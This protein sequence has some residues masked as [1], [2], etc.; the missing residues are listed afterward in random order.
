MSI[1]QVSIKQ[2][3]TMKRHLLIIPFFF[4]STLLFAQ[5]EKTS[6]LYTA[7]L[8]KDSLLFNV[9]FNTCD[10]SQFEQLVSDNFEFYHDKGGMV[11]TKADFISSIKS[12][13]CDNDYQ[14]I[15]TLDATSIEIYPLYTN[16]ILY[17]AIQNGNHRFYALEENAPMYLT[18]EAKFTHVWLLENEE[19][20]LSRSLSFNHI[21]FDKPIDK[22][23]LFKDKKETE[24]WLKQKGI[25]ALGI[26]YI[27]NGRIEQV[28]VFG[29]LQKGTEAPTNTLW[30]V[31]S[32]TK[33]I[34]TL[35]TLKLASNGH[36]DLDEPVYHYWIDPD[37]K[38]D[39][40]HKTMTTRHI[41]SH[42]TGFPNWRWMDEEAQNK[43]RFQFDP[44][45]A[46]QYSGEGFEYLK[47]ALE[48]KFNTS[49]EELADSLIFSPLEMEDTQ[50]FWDQNTDES[51]FA[52]WHT[53]DGE[54]Y[55]T[56]KNTEASAADDVLT[57]VE[58]YTTFIA[59]LLNGAELSA[60]LQK[61]LTEEQ[62][63]VNAY[64]Y[65]GLGFWVDENIN[66]SGDIA[67][68]HGGDDV[69]V[70]T[71]AFML[72]STKQGLVIFT[73]SDNGTAAFQEVLLHFLGE[74]GQGIL[75]VEMR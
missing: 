8:E 68:V 70:H 17:G 12:G 62:V 6:K 53:A 35:L 38:S 1:D 37:V 41:L 45:T 60:P 72:P 64:K 18:S 48:S 54:V 47:H 24:R 13:V 55:E 74:N 46:Y 73:N 58:D 75:D 50:F 61:E 28:S 33:P 22:E 27:E 20:K 31:A 4:L 25:P 19:W 69:G 14:A 11:K 42:Q 39:K 29:E 65:W 40:R 66:E 3:H 5:I 32:L 34:V 49:L 16:G 21:A 23:L 56:F 36:W 43:L 44:G 9:G 71:I 63:R 51:R 30:N 26:G 7:I 59:Y 57:T 10:M 52:K 15:R 67:F 2:N